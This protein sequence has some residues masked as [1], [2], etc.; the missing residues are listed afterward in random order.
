MQLTEQMPVQA[1]PLCSNY[2]LPWS[3][4]FKKSTPSGSETRERRPN[5]I[6]SALATK[7]YEQ[8]PNVPPV[9]IDQYDEI[10]SSP[11][12]FCLRKIDWRVGR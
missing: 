9:W 10:V 8:V 7:L 6:S 3:M 1:R 5:S 4:V 12:I 2:R 11:V